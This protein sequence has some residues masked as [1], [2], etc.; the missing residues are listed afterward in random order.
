MAE[1]RGVQMQEEDMKYKAVESWLKQTNEA[2]CRSIVAEK[3]MRNLIKFF[4]TAI[5]THC[6]NPVFKKPFQLSTVYCVSK[7]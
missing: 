3:L 4:L 2:V 1:T 5:L 7:Q 6:K